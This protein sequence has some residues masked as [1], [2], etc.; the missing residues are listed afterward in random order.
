METFA[1]YFNNVR[2][3]SQ[4]ARNSNYHL[5]KN[6]I[7][8]VSSACSH[9][10]LVVNLHYSL[11][12]NLTLADVGRSSQRECQS[13]PCLDESRLAF[14]TLT[15]ISLVGWQMGYPLSFRP[16]PPRRSLVQPPHVPHRRSP[17]S[18]RLSLWYRRIHTTQD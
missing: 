11:V 10:S 12:V 14:M 6:G 1:R 3:P 18:R 17:R 13:Q 8:P 16:T 4:L 7:K 2:L 15:D 9:Y 5:F